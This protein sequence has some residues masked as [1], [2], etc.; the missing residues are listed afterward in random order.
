M[1]RVYRI[2]LWSEKKNDKQVVKID[3]NTTL[4]IFLPYY[5]KCLR[6][7]HVLGLWRSL[8]LSLLRSITFEPAHTVSVRG[9]ARSLRNAVISASVGSEPCFAS[10]YAVNSKHFW[11]SS[12]NNRQVGDKLGVFGDYIQSL[13]AAQS[14]FPVIPN[15]QD[16]VNLSE[17]NSDDRQS[18]DQLE[19]LSVMIFK[20]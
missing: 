8:A 3:R 16:L 18:S 1:I 14:V 2:K 7:R 20:I 15:A 12:A 5:R 4:Q 10:E 17:C 11:S 13:K 9:K 19:C 6:C